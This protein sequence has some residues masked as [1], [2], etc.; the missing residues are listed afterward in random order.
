MPYLHLSRH[1]VSSNYYNASY[2][3]ATIL[4]VTAIDG[5]ESP[6]NI[7]VTIT[8]IKSMTDAERFIHA[9]GTVNLY[10]VGVL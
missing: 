7:R 1:Q 6:I 9:W 5:V 10:V 3:S 2:D 8:G 4:P